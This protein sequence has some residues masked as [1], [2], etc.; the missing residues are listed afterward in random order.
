MQL[1]TNFFIFFLISYIC[2]N[3]FMKNSEEVQH[4]YPCDME[5]K[6]G[7]DNIR[8]IWDDHPNYLTAQHILSFKCDCILE[9]LNL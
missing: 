4:Q 9:L 2:L 3:I 6:Y 1:C 8:L 5:G 7:M